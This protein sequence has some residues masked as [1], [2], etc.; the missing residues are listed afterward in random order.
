MRNLFQRIR[1][2]VVT[3][4]HTFVQPAVF[5][6]YKKTYVVLVNLRFRVI[7]VFPDIR[8]VLFRRGKYVIAEYLPEL[9][10]CIHV[11]QEQ[12]ARADMRRGTRKGLL[13]LTIFG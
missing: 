11:K 5:I 6:F 8:R 13:Q 9:V 2:F 1:P 7:A 12:P 10:F 3:F 4:L